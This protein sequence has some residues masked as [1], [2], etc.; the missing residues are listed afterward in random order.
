MR[1]TLNA[2]KHCIAALIATCALNAWSSPIA[3]VAN[4]GSRTLSVL[5]TA[6]DTV[7]AE[8]AVGGKPRGT[9]IA[10]DGLTAYVSDA[11]GDRLAIVDLAA[12]KLRAQIA[13][14]R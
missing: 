13:L 3:Y 6:T 12:R 11:A 5:D 10:N 7:L 4:E 14:G 8:I 9:A 2:M 1:H